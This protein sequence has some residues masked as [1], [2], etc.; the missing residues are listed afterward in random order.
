M[1]TEQQI[2]LLTQT[3]KKSIE[4]LKSKGADYATEDILSNFKRISG[5]I[6]SLNLDI[7]TPQGYAMFMTLMK[8]DRIN[9]LLTSKKQPKNE[10]IE[11]SFLDGINYFKLAYCAYKEDKL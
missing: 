6:K 10:S 2:E 3:D 4:I 5:A 7:T 9:N 1:T 8:L 11:D